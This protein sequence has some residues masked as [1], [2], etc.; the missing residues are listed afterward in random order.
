MTGHQL[1]GMLS[2]LAGLLSAVLGVR[3]GCV[4]N[5]VGVPYW[6]GSACGKPQVC[7]RWQALAGGG[8]NAADES[9]D[10]DQTRD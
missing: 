7:P 6:I 5:E 3:H 10:V 1:T 8:M 9:V 2:A 4:S